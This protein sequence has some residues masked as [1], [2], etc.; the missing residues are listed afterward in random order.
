MVPGIPPVRFD[1]DGECIIETDPE[2]KIPASGQIPLSVDQLKELQ[3]QMEYYV[4]R[5]FWRPSSAPYAAP[6]LFAPKLRDD[7]TFDGYRLCVDYR[8][9][10]AITKQDKFPLPNPETLI[11]RPHAVFSSNTNEARGHS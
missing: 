2:A 7:G 9:L 3:A 10:N 11:A 8:K 6:I 5:G 1:R 4:P